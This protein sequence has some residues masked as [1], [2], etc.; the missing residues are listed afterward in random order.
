MPPWGWVIPTIGRY[1]RW[2]WAVLLLAL[3][4]H[5]CV[6]RFLQWH[7]PQH[8]AWMLAITVFNCHRVCAGDQHAAGPEQTFSQAQTDVFAP[9]REATPRSVFKP[10]HTGFTCQSRTCSGTNRAVLVQEY[11]LSDPRT[12]ACATPMGMWSINR[13]VTVTFYNRF[14]RF[15]H[16][17]QDRFA[18]RHAGGV[19][20]RVQSESSMQVPLVLFTPQAFAE[21]MR[22]TQFANG[23]I[24][25]SCWHCCATTWCCG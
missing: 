11:A 20:L 15:R 7:P 12:Y 8:C 4:L 18:C 24:T 1:A 16:Q 22:D 5:V 9:L 19:L 25:A 6:Q 13:A 21:L 10:V 14:V 23:C 2:R 17:F 3:A